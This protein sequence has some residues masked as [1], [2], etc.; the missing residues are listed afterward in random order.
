MFLQWLSSPSPEYI[1]LSLVLLTLLAVRRE[2]IYGASPKVFTSLI[3]IV[4]CT[5]VVLMTAYV[6][7]K[8]LVEP[9]QA[10]K[11]VPRV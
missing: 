11:R 2:R 7:G 8:N 3:I 6:R 5:F 4:L 10:S 1:I 9:P